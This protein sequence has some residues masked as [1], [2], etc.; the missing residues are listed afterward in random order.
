MDPGSK[1]KG[2]ASLYHRAGITRL[3]L[4]PVRAQFFERAQKIEF[5]EL[6]GRASKRRSFDRSS[7]SLFAEDDKNSL[8]VCVSNPTIDVYV[9]SY[10]EI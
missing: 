1:H 4:H 7:S 10:H 2:E 6:S 5:A 8:L 3:A 9:C